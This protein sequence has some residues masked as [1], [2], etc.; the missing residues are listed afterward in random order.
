MMWGIKGFIT[1]RDAS[2]SHIG[3]D[4]TMLGLVAAIS[5]A[6]VTGVL[7]AL[8]WVSGKGTAS[9]AHPPTSV[10]FRDF[11][12]QRTKEFMDGRD[13][14]SFVRLVPEENRAEFAS[15]LVAFLQAVVESSTATGLAIL[16]KIENIETVQASILEKSTETMGRLDMIRNTIADVERLS[17]RL[18][19][20]VRLVDSIHMMSKQIRQNLRVA[21]LQTVTYF[22]AGLAVGFIGNVLAARPYFATVATQQLLFL[23]ASAFVITASTQVIFAVAARRSADV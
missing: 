19:A 14:D 23:L 20:N 8:A 13:L 10:E 7:A 17:Q 21:S 12:E 1:G 3:E 5:A 18:A 15:R 9:S 2:M 22:L 11:V 6:V 16:L 4:K